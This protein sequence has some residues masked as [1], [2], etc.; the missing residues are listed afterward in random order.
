MPSINISLCDVTE[1]SNPT[2]G[3]LINLLTKFEGQPDAADLLCSELS[4]RYPHLSVSHPTRLLDIIKCL[5]G[6]TRPSIRG[7]TKLVGTPLATYRKRVWKARTR[8]R[9]QTLGW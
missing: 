1:C 9:T 2:Y 4:A 5:A 6:P 8:T 7:P 3:E